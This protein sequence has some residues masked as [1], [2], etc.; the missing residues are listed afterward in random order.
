MTDATPN[1]ETLV[2][3]SKRGLEHKGQRGEERKNRH[4]AESDSD[5]Q[6]QVKFKRKER[7]RKP[8]DEAPR[9]DGSAVAGLP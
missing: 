9:Y 4:E 8:N 2:Q 3:Y 5:S 7:A 6:R 1:T